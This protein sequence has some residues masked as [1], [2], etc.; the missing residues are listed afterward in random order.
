[1]S[2]ALLFLILLAAPLIASAA[3]QTFSDLVHSFVPIIN[4]GTSLLIATT[5]VIY[6]FGAARR[7]FKTGSGATDGK[8]MNR[9]LLTGVIII[10]FMVSIAGLVAILE[11]TLFGG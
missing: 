11:N 9:F 2:R 8:E 7:L 3:P 6:F 1:M 5:I 4:G 10:F